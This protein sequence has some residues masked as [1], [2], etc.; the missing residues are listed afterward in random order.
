[1][2]AQPQQ[3][4][5]AFGHSQLPERRQGG[6]VTPEDMAKFLLQGLIAQNDA[7]Q[8]QENYDHAEVSAEFDCPRPE[9]G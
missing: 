9:D 6:L 2:I 5:P 7:E 4:E 8:C 3:P 1:M